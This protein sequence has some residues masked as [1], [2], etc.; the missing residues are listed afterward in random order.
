LPIPKTNVQNAL[1]SR[2]LLNKQLSSKGKHTTP[3]ATPFQPLSA[4]TDQKQYQNVTDQILQKQNNQL[5]NVKQQLHE[6]MMVSI[7]EV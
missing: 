2:A 1:K 4:K 5:E 7:K 6:K 3:L